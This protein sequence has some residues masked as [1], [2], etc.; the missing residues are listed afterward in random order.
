VAAA[1]LL[2]G[3]IA[4]A[5][6][7]PVTTAT[8]PAVGPTAGPTAPTPSSAAS[9]TTALR[10]VAPKGLLIG[11]SVVGGGHL[12]ATDHPQ[13][14]ETDQAYRQL[15]ATQF[16]TLTPENALKWAEV[17]PARDQYDFAAA[18]AVVAFAE[19]HGQQ[20]RGHNL[21]W[22]QDNPAWLTGG[23][24]SKAELT[25]ILHDHISTVVGHYKGKIAAWDVANEIFDESG[26]VR[27]GNPFIDALGIDIVGDAFRWAHEADPAAVLYLNDYNVE[28]STAKRLA[29]VNLVQQLQGQG[30]PIGGMGV[31]SH[32]ALKYPPFPPDFQ[33]T[34]E[35]FAG[36][37]LDVAITELDVRVQLGADGTAP[38][39]LLETQ[40]DWYAKVVAACLAV[41]KCVSITMW[42]AP[43]TYSWVPTYFPD[44]GAATPFADAATPKPAFAAM[45]AALRK[46]RL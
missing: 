33:N 1:F 14:F 16:S 20:V 38:E 23:S 17:E 30:V 12:S 28:T 42:G 6:P 41:P 45:V 40:A 8:V 32:L 39:A 24:F 4:P 11:S 9:P 27:A 2:A 26:N 29:Y 36:L 34:L 25:Q 15:L 18:D 46:G 3:C 22:Y 13:P 21:L 37:G 10:D 35:A 5:T 31:Q 43:D 44:E 7:A 19:Q